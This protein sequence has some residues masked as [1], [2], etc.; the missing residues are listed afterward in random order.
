MADKL[1]LEYGLLDHI[2]PILNQYLTTLIIVAIIVIA[3]MCLRL[4]RRPRKSLPDTESRLEDEKPIFE[5]P[6][7]PSELASEYSH[8]LAQALFQQTGIPT[9]GD[10][11]QREYL[12]NSDL[13]RCLSPISVPTSGDLAAMVPSSTLEEQRHPWRRHSYPVRQS[14]EGNLS[15]YQ[16]EAVI[17]GDA[18]DFF[19]DDK[20][21]KLWRRRTLEFGLIR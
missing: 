6:P 15:Q 5:L 9:S 4:R 14:F 3:A 16:R 1:G 7:P 17:M 20:A 8:P 19:R 2:M 18:V 12:N 11:A 10:F 13:V 21:G